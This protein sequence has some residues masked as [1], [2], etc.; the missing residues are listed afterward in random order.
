VW[1]RSEICLQSCNLEFLDVYTC[2]LYARVFNRIEC[3]RD[4][5]ENIVKLILLHHHHHCHTTIILDVIAMSQY[6]LVPF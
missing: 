5:E 1:K 4:N 6:R 3:E 2:M